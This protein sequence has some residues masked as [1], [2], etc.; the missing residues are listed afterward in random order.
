MILHDITKR[1]FFALQFSFF[2]K[3]GRRKSKEIVKS[4]LP[5]NQITELN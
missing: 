2:A 3:L 4:A 5:L 1:N